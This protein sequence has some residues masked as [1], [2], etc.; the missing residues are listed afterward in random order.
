M[1]GGGQDVV[2]LASV[3]AVGVADEAH[4]LEDVERPIDGRGDRAGVDGP[5]AL[6]EL[7]A[8]DVAVGGGQDR[9]EQPPLGRPAE[10]AL[11][12]SGRG[13][14]PGD[15]GRSSTGRLA[16]SGYAP[17]ATEDSR[18]GPIG[19]SCAALLIRPTVPRV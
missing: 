15:V 8:G 16:D 17:I 11:A 10:P 1:I 3:G 2:L 9:D 14:L 4:L 6:D 19:R 18:I 13:A 5:A 12:E 7:G